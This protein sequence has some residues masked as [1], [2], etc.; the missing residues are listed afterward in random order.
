MDNKRGLGIEITTIGRFARWTRVLLA[1]WVATAASSAFATQEVEP[2]NTCALAQILGAIATNSPITVNG[3]L[4]TTPTAPD[5]DFYKV[6]GGTPG[7]ILRVLVTGASDGVDTL[8]LPVAAILSSSC[9]IIQ[10]SYAGDPLTFDFVVPA[11]GVAILAVTSYPDFS[12]A[13]T[14]F[15]SGSYTLTA[16]EIIPV[17]SI[18]GRVVD[19]VTGQPVSGVQATLMLCVDATCTTGQSMVNEALTDT[20]GQFSFTVTTFNGAPLAPGTYQMAINDYSGRYVPAQSPAFPAASGR[21]VVV[22][23]IALAP[24]PVIGSVSGRIVD[25]VTHAPLSGVGEPFVQIILAGC[26]GYA[27]TY[28]TGSPD[29]S[30]RF[31]FTHDANGRG[32]VANA[33]LTMSVVADQYQQLYTTVLPIAAGADDKLGD[34]QLMSNPVRFTVLHGCTNVPIT[35]GVCEY[36]VQITNG[37]ANPVEGAAWATIDAV[38][39]QSFIGGSLFQTDQPQEMYLA[40]ATWTYRASRVASFEFAIPGTVPAFAFICPTFWFGVDPVN[41]QLYVQGST[42]AFMNCVQ[43]TATGYTP[44]TPDQADRLRKERHEHE[45]KERQAVM[46]H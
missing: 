14:G 40:G 28:V 19:A 34:I 32:I 4:K 22:P 23:D 33:Q 27:C 30:G 20:S 31:K 3:S 29:S 36:K 7:D 44:A 42:T 10:S 9:S 12:L 13:G 41:P 2:N 39:L 43:R 8:S 6:S 38:G 11:D 17:Q 25:S 15:Y 24:T 46:P 45:V 26:A 1:V 5:V 16:T 21:Q 18:S 37:G 35:G